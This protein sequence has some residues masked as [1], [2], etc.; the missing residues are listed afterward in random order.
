MEEER[1]LTLVE[2]E[3]EVAEENNEVEVAEESGS[4]GL[5]AALGL[6]GVGALVY[7]GRKWG[8]PVYKKLKDKH[9]KKKLDKALDLVRESGYDTVLLDYGDD[10]VSDSEVEVS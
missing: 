6:A 2:N 10:E 7:V 8:M 5:V 1:N 9:N 3:V 4:V